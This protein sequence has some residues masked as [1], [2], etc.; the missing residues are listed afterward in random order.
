V[1]QDY[2]PWFLEPG[3]VLY[4]MIDQPGLGL[5]FYAGAFLVAV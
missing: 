5:L 1:I 3:F 2:S 4:M